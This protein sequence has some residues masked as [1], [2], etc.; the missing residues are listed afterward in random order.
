MSRMF[1]ASRQQTS[2]GAP[3]KGSIEEERNIWGILPLPMH[4]QRDAYQSYLSGQNPVRI[5]HAELKDFYKSGIKDF[6]SYEKD[7]CVP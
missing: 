5:F 4:L 6:K 7:E 2:D 3:S 1:I